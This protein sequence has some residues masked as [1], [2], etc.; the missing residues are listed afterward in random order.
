MP[1]TENWIYGQI[2]SLRKY[3]PLVYCHDII[4]AAAFTA[5]RIRSAG[6]LGK[7]WNKAFKFQPAFVFFLLKDKPDIVHCHFGPSG[8]FF[9]PLKRIFRLPLITAF[10]GNDLSELPRQSRRWRKRYGKL[11]RDGDCFLVEG[12]HMKQ[13]LADLGCPAEKIIIQHIGVD[14]EKIKFVPRCVKTGDPIK[15]LI[16]ARFRQKK[17]IPCAVEAFGRL[18]NKRPSLNMRLTVIG[19]SGKDAGSIAEKTKIL[20]KIDEYHLKDRITLS[21]YQPYCSFLEELYRHHIFISASMVAASGDM[22]GGAP[23]SIIEASASGMPVISTRHC[24]IPQVIIDQE[25]GYLVAEG[26]SCGLAEKLELLAD[27]VDLW[28][29]MG[30]KAR[31]HIEGKYDMAKQARRLEEIYDKVLCDRSTVSMV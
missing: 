15:V 21:G 29:E 1:L 6:F 7:V 28:P 4:N 26:D 14:L 24:D 31:R 17:G 27:N 5:A 16:S 12:P 22:E 25:T 10:Y 30:L 20:A 3:K 23:V 13:V 2:K 9:L 19:D 18:I 11:F 8:Y